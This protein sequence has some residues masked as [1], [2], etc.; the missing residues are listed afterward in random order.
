MH[1]WKTSHYPR[2]E[3]DYKSTMVEVALATAAT[4]TYF[5]TYRSAAGAPLIDGGMWAN[6]PVAEAV[7]EAIGVLKLATR[8]Y[9]G[10]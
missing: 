6:N 4:P 10:S 8:I 2:L 5:P 1:I 7:V 9:A 3:R